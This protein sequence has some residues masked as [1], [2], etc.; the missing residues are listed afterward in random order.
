MDVISPVN[1]DKKLNELRFYLFEEYFIF[2][3]E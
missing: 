1:F 2:E 3:N